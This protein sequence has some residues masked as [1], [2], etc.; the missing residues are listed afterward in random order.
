[1]NKS[2]FTKKIDG[3]TMMEMLTVMVIV[4]ILFLIAMPVVEPLI[5]KAK[6]TEAKTQLNHVYK[7]EKSYYYE[8]SKYTNDLAAIGF[9]QVNLKTEEGG[10]ANYRIEVVEA[11][12][13]SFL[14]KAT[15]VIDFDSDGN[16]NTWEIDEKQ[17]LKESIPD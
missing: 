14:V 9:E 4:G 6:A 7:L 2:F 8:Y 13:N 15:A 17:N 10:Q 3:L 5:A 16:F 12:V 1:M 11:S